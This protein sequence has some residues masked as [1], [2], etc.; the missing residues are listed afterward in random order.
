[1]ENVYFIPEN[2]TDF[3][4]EVLDFFGENV[5]V[6]GSSSIPGVYCILTPTRMYIGCSEVSI[7]GRLE[8]H[9]RNPKN[10]LL[11][12]SMRKYWN[13][14]LCCFF[15]LRNHGDVYS[16][17]RRFIEDSRI[18]FPGRVINISTGGRGVTGE[19][20]GDFWDNA[21][22]K[23]LMK[24]RSKIDGS[25]G[26]NKLEIASRKRVE[27]LKTKVDENT[28]ETVWKMMYKKRILNLKNKIDEETGLNGLQLSKKKQQE[29]L[30]NRIDEETGLNGLQT[31]HRKQQENL[32]NRIDEETGL[33]GLQISKKKQEET[34][35][36]RIDEETGLNGMQIAYRKRAETLREIDPETGLSKFQLIARK[37]SETIRRKKILKYLL[38]T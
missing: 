27:N 34:L 10:R 31:A 20:I 12:N 38:T 14:G 9:I 16:S 30:R 21:R 8:Y 24:M 2:L 19:R 29:T 3:Q 11:G 6:E 17:E 15:R 18:K 4:K 33:N 37:R 22:E 7:K 35:R 36:N 13:S 28:G 1:M 23:R 26:L 5:I 32:R 25:T